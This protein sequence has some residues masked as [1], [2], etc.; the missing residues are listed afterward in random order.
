MR[1]S[2]LKENG[3]PK[4]G[5]ELLE[6]ENDESFICES[7]TC[8]FKITRQKRDEL[9]E[10]GDDDEF[11]NECQNCGKAS[12]GFRLCYRCDREESDGY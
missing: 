9:L 5:S 12:K 8:D 2:N 6:L 4:C 1:W 11:A 10:A 7:A 3:C